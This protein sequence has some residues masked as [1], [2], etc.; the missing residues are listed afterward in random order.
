MRR[1]MID[2]RL[3]GTGPLGLRGIPAGCPSAPP[4]QPRLRLGAARLTAQVELMETDCPYLTPEPHRGK[5]NEPAYVRYVVE[6]IARARGVWAGEVA[7][8]ALENALRLFGIPT[9]A[10]S[11]TA[12]PRSF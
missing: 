3:L 8:A 10:S 7:P 9:P 12:T 4:A 5:R 6:A 1:T 2:S 11:T